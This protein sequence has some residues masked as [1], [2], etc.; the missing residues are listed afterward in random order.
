MAGNEQYRRG[1]RMLFQM[2]L[3]ILADA[4]D[5][6]VIGEHRD[7]DGAG[8]AQSFDQLVASE[9]QSR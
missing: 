1:L 9:R 7:A 2:L 6:G 3:D 8:G 5:I 4:C